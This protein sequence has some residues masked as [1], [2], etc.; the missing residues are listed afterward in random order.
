MTVSAEP[1]DPTVRTELDH[2]RSRA[3][4]VAGVGAVLY[5]VVALATAHWSTD[6]GQLM[7][8]YLV[9]FIFWMIPTL[10]SM[11]LLMI[12]Y[13]TGGKWGVMLRRIFEANTRCYPLMLLLF[14]PVAV[15]V[16]LGEESPYLWARPL[17]VVYPGPAQ[18]AWDAREELAHRQHM[19]LNPTMF[20]GFSALFL[21]IW[22]G[23]IFVLNRWSA[24]TDRTGDPGPR[25]RLINVSGPGVIIY[26]LTVTFAVLYWVMSLELNW[27]STMFPVIFAITQFLGAYAFS[28]IVLLWLARRPPL[29]HAVTPGEQIHLGSLL[30]ALTLFWTYVSFA[31]FLLVWVGNLP[32]E[33]PWY[34]KRSR[35]GWEY[36]AWSLGILHFALPF[37]L[38]LFRDVKADRR[39]LTWVA[40]LI[41]VMCGVDVLWW[42]EP[43]YADHGHVFFWVLD[44]AAIAAIG[45][46]WVW[47]FLGQLKQRDSLLPAREANLL[48][49]AHD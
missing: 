31:Q 29:D 48:E 37:L 28:V 43:T 49:H 6:Y 45:G 23:F 3:L 44:L 24:E 39:R 38:L 20:V 8:P 7:L 33:I 30:L 40:A 41:L 2:L 21:A 22:G 12:Q 46:V 10:G 47:W 34:L 9:G 42:I 19:F 35:G 1:L 17:E 13:L 16:F 14:V 11:V 5:A 18:A 36:V 32:E 4:I 26:A 15:S 25:R 27:A